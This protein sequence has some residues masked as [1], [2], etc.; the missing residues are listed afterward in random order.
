MVEMQDAAKGAQTTMT[1]TMNSAG[2]RAMGA[3]IG[4][5]GGAHETNAANVAGGLGRVVSGI[6]QI[7]FYIA[8]LRGAGML[9]RG[10]GAAGGILGAGGAGAAG[11]GGML[12]RLAGIGRFARL[13]GP[14]GLALGATA[15]SVGKI[16]SAISQRN[17]ETREADDAITSWYGP[18]QFGVLAGGKG[19][20][21][22]LSGYLGGAGDIAG[23][24]LEYFRKNRGMDSLKV[25]G[26]FAGLQGLYDPNQDTNITAIRG[27]LGQARLHQAMLQAYQMD[28]PNATAKDVNFGDAALMVKA[29]A[30]LQGGGTTTTE[31]EAPYGMTDA[32]QSNF[33]LSEILTALREKNNAV[34]RE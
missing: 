30:M 13:G 1:S 19:K 8:A 33:L 21:A 27:R 32:E 16:G 15:Y 31:A 23:D 3:H 5:L 26:A 17:A 10:A 2:M 20:G 28:H 18:N 25:G 6:G 12:S 14:V 29:Q 9:G 11:A 22:R 24:P 7:A 4:L 34:P